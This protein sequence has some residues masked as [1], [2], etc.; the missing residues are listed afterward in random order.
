MNYLITLS[1]YPFFPSP[2]QF[3]VVVKDDGI[4]PLQDSAHFQIEVTDV[5][6]HLP[7]FTISVSDLSK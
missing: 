4:P 7:D 1:S 2:M 6:D 3:D 5:D